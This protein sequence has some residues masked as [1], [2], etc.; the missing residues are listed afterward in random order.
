MVGFLPW[1]IKKKLKCKVTVTRHEYECP[2]LVRKIKYYL[3]FAK[4]DEIIVAE[5]EFIDRI[6]K[7][8]KKAK[9]RYIPI[10]SNISRSEITEEKK[11]ELLKKY[12]LKENKVISYFGFANS[13]KGIE[14]LFKSLSKLD[15][16]IKLLFINE[17]NENDEYQK[18]L[19]NLMKELKIEDRVVVTGFFD[20]ECDIADMLEISDVCVLPFINGVKTRNGS[21][22]AAYNQKIPVITT[23]ETL[24]DEK[25]IYYVKPK[26]EE[27]LL[28]KIKEVLERKEKIERDI[29]TWELVA[30]NHI[31]AFNNIL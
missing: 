13:L 1:I 21:F 22:L 29:L 24:K 27:E 17:L 20:N 30:K 14:Y 11:E 4:V 31:D 23:S 12:N 5:E 8:F 18:G 19:I 9:V 26:S 16:N 3:N 7:D 10:S 15:S 28:E 2:N 25:G 6:K